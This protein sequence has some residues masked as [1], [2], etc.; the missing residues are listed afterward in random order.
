MAPPATCWLATAPSALATP[1]AAE[2]GVVDLVGCGTAPAFAMA[3]STDRSADTATVSLALKAA[4]SASC[5]SALI[6]S[7][8]AFVSWCGRPYPAR[9]RRATDL[10][11]SATAETFA[12]L[13]SKGTICLC[14]R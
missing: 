7:P 10:S 1:A 12:A 9:P 3:A 6:A 8:S 14:E 4:C 5:S 13:R 11:A 2:V